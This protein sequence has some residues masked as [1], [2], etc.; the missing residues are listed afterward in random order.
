MRIGG[1]KH[2]YKWIDNWVTLPDTELG[3]QD[4]AHHGIVITAAGHIVVFHEGRIVE[5]GSV[6]SLF[7][8]PKHPYTRGLIASLPR[9]GQGNE[10]RLTAIPG[11]VP[12]AGAIPRGCPFHP[13]CSEFKRGVCDTESVPLLEEVAP[14]HRAACFLYEPCISAKSGGSSQEVQG[15]G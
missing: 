3:R 5:Q 8:D 15:G 10:N 1:G 12:D 2:A 6:D 13:R 11:T 7:N 9:I 14:G 4:K